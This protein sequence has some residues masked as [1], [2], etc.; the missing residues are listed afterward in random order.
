MNAGGVLAI[1]ENDKG[2]AEIEHFNLL[3]E[4]FGM[5]FNE[6]CYH[7]VEGTK[8]DM[9]KSDVL[10]AHPIFDGVKKIYTKEVSSITVV[11][12]AEA[13]LTE[14]GVVLM[15]VAKVGKGTVFAVGDPWLYNEY[16]DNRRLPA[17]FENFKAARNLFSWLLDQ[18]RETR[19]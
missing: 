8:F 10:P 12:P 5:H 7:K 17:D 14:N 18:A 1:F 19:R 2:N 13:L 4:K 6:D 16:I 3:A 9:A 15:A 11:P